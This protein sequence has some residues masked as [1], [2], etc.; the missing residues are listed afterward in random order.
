[1]NVRSVHPILYV[2]FLL[3]GCSN[4]KSQQP[5]AAVMPDFKFYRLDDTPFTRND[6]TAGKKSMVILFDTSCEHCQHEMEDIGSRYADFKD[7]NFYLVSLDDKPEITGFMQTF[8][9]ELNG[10]DNVTVLQD[11]DHLFIPKFLPTKYPAMYIY[12]AKQQLIEYIGGQKDVE[13][14][15]AALKSKL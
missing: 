2:F 7:I 11:K 9:K 15:I 4:A 12:S 3:A 14:V 8:G 5:K 1:M 13:D 6:I 10:K